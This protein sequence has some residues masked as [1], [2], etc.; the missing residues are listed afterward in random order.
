VIEEHRSPTVYVYAVARRSGDFSRKPLTGVGAD[1]APV[2]AVCHG[3]LAALVSTVPASWRAARRAD[4]EA[5]DRV[6]SEL[7]GE[8]FVPMRFGVLM[9]DEEEVRERLLARHAD[10]LSG[11]LDRVEGRVQMSL[12]AYY[13]DEALLRTVLAR[14]PDLKQRS[15]ALEGRPVATT[16]NER[17]ALGRDVAAAVEEQ[18]ALDQHVVV[19]P[20]A[21]LVDELR[22]EPSRSE[23]HA[24]TSQLLIEAARRADLDAAV[25]RLTTEHGGR[26]A[27]RYVGPLPPYSF[28][29]MALTSGGASWG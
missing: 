27:F 6:L 24:F 19:V 26:F 4:I 16:Q 13:L 7:I 15:D 18:R 3:E 8:T 9:H 17:I 2:R 14:R 28:C 5:H 21:G 29:D 12:K 22:V 1:P 20:L 23:R 10:E 25:R 11:L